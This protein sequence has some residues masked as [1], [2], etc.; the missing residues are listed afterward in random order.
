MISLL[1]P[2]KKKRR[3]KSRGRRRSS[4]CRSSMSPCSKAGR[5]RFYRAASRCRK[6]R[7]ARSAA[8][9]AR[10]ES[11]WF[12]K[13][14]AH[15]PGGINP[16]RRRRGRN[17]SW[18][19]GYA[20]NPGSLVGSATKG[21]SLNAITGVVPVAAGAFG[22]LY[23]SRT[24]SGYAPSIITGNTIGQIGLG[25]ASAGVLAGA[26]GMV[27]PKY[28]G[29]VLLGGLAQVLTGLIR[30]TFM[31]D[32]ETVGEKVYPIGSLGTKWSD[33][34]AAHPMNTFFA[35]N[36]DSNIAEQAHQ[37]AVTAA[38]DQDNAGDSGDQATEATV[39]KM[40]GLGDYLTQMQAADARS[41]G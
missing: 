29:Q 30:S 38:I 21:F 18:I 15:T 16:R 31:G 6:A 40:S 10:R 9:A 37:A 5:R 36:Q 3:R 1:N 8:A 32:Y 12:R 7:A 25:V 11:A 13:I 19:P 28:S 26:V 33:D 14:A 35:A 17:P 39:A 24:I 4:A 2:G 41:L 22:N 27:A 34:Y 23:L 20:T